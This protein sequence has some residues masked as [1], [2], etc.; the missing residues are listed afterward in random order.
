M[1]VHDDHFPQDVQD[2]V[3]LRVVGRKGWVVL[4]K[5]GR[6]RYR[7]AEKRALLGGGVAAFVLTA[8]G[9]LTGK[10]TAE[11]F[12]KALPRIKRFLAKHKPPFLAG[13]S[14]SGIVRLMVQDR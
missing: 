2:S 14:R 12:V 10:E 8:R 9:D 1:E 3:W 5:D 11:I 4:T 7:P 13:V 6:I